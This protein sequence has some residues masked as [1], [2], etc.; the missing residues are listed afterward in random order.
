LVGRRV[1][2][3]SATTVH[4]FLS[5]AGLALLVVHLGGLLV[6][7]FMPFGLADLTIPFASTYRPLAIAIGV[8]AMYAM[9][10]VIVLSWLRKRIG[11]VWW[12]R[13]HLL[14]VP[15]FAMSALHG[16]LA[17]SDSSRA[18]MWWLY[19]GTSL[20]VVFLVIVRGLTANVRPVRAP[21]PA[22]TP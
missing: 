11:T 15:T 3:A 8:V 21:R 19:L 7:S 5:T 18:A 1:S 12:R 9:V 4:Q 20:T 6:D 13:S 14:A 10:A 2:R 17:G 22:A 16:L